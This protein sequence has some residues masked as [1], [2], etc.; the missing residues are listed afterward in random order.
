MTLEFIKFE[1][2]TLRKRRRSKII[3]LYFYYILFFLLQ[4]HIINMEVIDK[5]ICG[6][7]KVFQQS[8][9]SKHAI[10]LSTQKTSNLSECISQCC[11]INSK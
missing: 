4:Q 2:V 11:T 5:N 6:E 3:C 8:W 7:L 10:T 1:F 9:F